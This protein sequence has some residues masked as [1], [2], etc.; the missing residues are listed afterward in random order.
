MKKYGMILFALLVTIAFVAPA[1]AVEF[2]YGVCI[3]F[4]GSPI[5]M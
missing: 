3:A 5:T 2:K 1:F 4:V